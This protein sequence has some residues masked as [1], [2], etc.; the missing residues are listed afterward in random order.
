MKH[1]TVVIGL[2]FILALPALAQQGEDR[3]TDYAQL[4]SP[5]KVYLHTDR[6]VYN[7]GDTIWFK[8]YLDNAAQIAEFPACNYLYVELISSMFQRNVNLGRS[9]ESEQVRARVKIKRREDGFIGWLVVPDNLNTG[10]AT[11]RAYSYWMLN[12]EPEYMFHKDVEIRNPMKD[13]F[14][15]NLAKE[16][17][18]DDYKYTD[19]GMAN[20]F[21][22]EKSVKRTL[23]I[24]FLPES[25]RWLYGQQ[26]VLGIRSVD[27]EGHGIP[28]HGEIFADEVPAGRFETD[29]RGLGRAVLLLE[30][31]VRKLYAQVYEGE[32]FAGRFELP[33]PVQAGAVIHI[34]V[35]DD[36][37]EAS[38]YDKGLLLPD[39]TF[40]VVHDRDEIYIRMPYSLKTRNLKIP[41]ALLSP[42]IN[43][44]AL[45]G[46]DG[47]VYA[48][49]AFFVYPRQSAFSLRTD[50]P[51][52]GPRERVSVTTDLPEG[53][54]SVSVSD[55]GYAPYSGKGYDLVS[56]WYLGSELPSFVEEAQS[57][58]DETRPLAERIRAMDA[59]MLTHGWTY[60]E[61]PKI[62]SGETAMPYFGKEY[63][64][65]ISGVV[66]GSLRTARKSIVSFIAPAIGFSAMGQLDTS[67]YF[68]LNGLD[69]PENTQFLVAAVSLG[70][71]TRRFT[72]YLD[73]DIFAKF[74]HY[75][76]YLD[77]PSYSQEYKQNILW[78][79]YNAGGEIIYSLHPSYVTGSASPQ[80]EN[81]SPLPDYEFKPGQYR[82]ER[83]LEP[84]KA[85]DVLTY[86]VTT[87]PPLRFAEGDET[88]MGLF[89]SEQSDST[90]AVG[91]T[92]RSVVCRTQKVS[93]V[94]GISSGW[95]E[96]IVF[97][98]GMRSSC[99]ELEGINV[100]D[101]TGFAYITGADAMMF[102]TG[103]DNALAPKSVVMV[104]TR[105]FAHGSAA[106]V[107]TGKPLGWQQ[108]QH[109]YN[110]R[111]V[112]AAS[113]RAPE[114]IRATLYWNP[115]F[116]VDGAETASFSFYT[117][118]HK[119]D[120]TIVIEGFTREGVPVSI[121]GKVSR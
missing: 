2:W 12:R 43:N 90:G 85:M 84:Y 98:N 94:M 6:E 9:L 16:N 59:V 64:Q 86:I 114:P 51:Q 116:E 111:Y 104:K 25:G 67:G 45:V 35:R 32:V 37:V 46:R 75:P 7:V 44:L 73:E 97:M 8:G 80:Q 38:V 52:Y 21:D 99:E 91:P 115:D 121:K 13:D 61:L 11:L 103:L 18:K 88:P 63:T 106:N 70:G 87:C 54:Y 113:R 83:E 4:L 55:D 66:R 102:N 69:F 78:D 3:F 23:D 81:I 15:D 48:E 74:H 31:P 119:A 89:T 28:V 76:A 34:S 108:P 117:S 53:D 5:E 10:I 96:I 56:W 65:S 26:A 72:P 47:T 112:D 101:L 36:S 100:S 42:G 24:Q 40:L 105:S 92:Y 22:K 107:S 17:V 33:L 58:F 82:P 77:K 14:V 109:F 118:D 39:S 57:Y 49:R 120:A 29:S 95:E 60:Y 1:R 19:V 50:K 68:V 79:Y 30:K 62:L 110:P 93:T 20:P 71:N 41:Y 27:P